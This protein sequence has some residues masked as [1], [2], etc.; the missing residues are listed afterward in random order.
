M[1][2][3]LFT[4][5]Y[6]NKIFTIFNTTYNR[7]T[8]LELNAEGKYI[9][10]TIEDFIELHNIYNRKRDE[11]YEIKLFNNNKNTV[12]APLKPR[13]RVTFKEKVRDAARG[14]VC[15]VLV[16]A[17]TVGLA[18]SLFNLEF[19]LTKENDSIKIALQVM[20]GAN[21]DDTKN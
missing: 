10:P 2:Q 18:P 6:K 9:Y 17:L 4:I 12:I 19:V 8:F 1:Y 11:L 13:T 3:V 20:K 14:I 7:K 21:I 16:V 5:E 15:S